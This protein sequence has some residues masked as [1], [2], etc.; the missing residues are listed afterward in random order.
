[1]FCLAGIDC[2]RRPL[3]MH[4]QTGVTSLIFS[5]EK[6]PYL[7]TLQKPLCDFISYCTVGMYV[8]LRKTKID[9]DANTFH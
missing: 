6:C 9:L 4:K 7:S 2:Y 8:H 5:Q 3:S 1:M